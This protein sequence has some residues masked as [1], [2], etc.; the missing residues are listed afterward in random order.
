MPENALPKTLSRHTAT[1]RRLTNSPLT[2]WRQPTG[3]P[4]RILLLYGSVRERSF[5]RLACEEAALLQTM[6]C[7]HV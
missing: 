6:G 4:P 7:P 2:G 3:P 5:S 1:G